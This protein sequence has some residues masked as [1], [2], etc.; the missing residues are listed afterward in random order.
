MHTRTPERSDTPAVPRRATPAVARRG[1]PTAA[2]RR[3]TA[4]RAAVLACTVWVFGLPIAADVAH[5]SR[6]EELGAPQGYLTDHAGVLDA[7]A[8]REIED[9][10][11][12]ID[13]VLQA[14]FAVVTV[15]ATEPMTIEEFGVKLFELWGIGQSK[16]DEGLLLVVAVEERAVRFEVGYGLEGALPDGRVGGI[17]RQQIL[18][19]FR[20]GDYAGGILDGI[21]E[22][23]RHVAESKG[24]AAPVPARGNSPRPPP[25]RETF[26]PGLLVL[27]LMA[28]IVVASLSRGNRGRRRGRRGGW[29]DPWYGGGIGWPMGGGGF[30]GGGGGGGFGGFGGG[31]S[32]GGG[33]TGRW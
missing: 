33:A 6:P 16:S 23:A 24:L 30:G 28:V 26:S 7:P 2:R 17:I 22:A 18:P 12:Q 27:V 11:T 29:N 25:R 8:R 21:T 5:G 4:R 13:T 31:A 20:G 32:G 3:D 15:R 9:Y 19:R 1:T 14:Q 10:L